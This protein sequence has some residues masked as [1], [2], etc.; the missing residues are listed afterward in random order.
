MTFT[1]SSEQTSIFTHIS[2]GTGNLIVS[3]C[4]GSGKTTTILHAFSHIP[5]SS[6]FVPPSVLYLVFN[7][8]NAT[9]AEDK[10][11]RMNVKNVTVS[12]FHALGMRALKS[13][14]LFSQADMQKRDFVNARK[15][16]RLVFNA[17][18]RENPDV[19]QVIRL[20]G[21]LKQQVWESSGGEVDVNPS[22]I[23]ALCAHFEIDLT[24]PEQSIKTALDILQ[25]STRDLS[26]IDFDDMLYLPIVLNVPFAPWDWV[27]TDEAQ[28]TNDVRMEIL[29]RLAKPFRGRLI[30]CDGMEDW[31]ALA[32]SS[33][34]FISVGDP[35]QAI[36]GFTGANSNALDKL[37]D[38]FQCTTLPLSISYRC[39]QNVVKESQPYG[40]IFPHPSAPLGEILRP[41]TYEPSMFKPPC[42]IVCRNT[43]PLV[44]FAYALLQ[45][46]IPCTVLGRDIGTQLTTLVKKM[47]ALNIVDLSD[48]L[49]AWHKRETERL[50]DKDMSTQ[51]IDDQ[52]EC[53]V[54][55]I[56]SL[57]EDSQSVASVLAKIDLMFSEEPGTSKVTLSTVHKAK[58]LEYPTVFILDRARYMPSRFARLPWQQEQERNLI[59]VAMTRAMERLV[60]IQ[61]ECWKEEKI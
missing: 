22:R 15:V 9:E 16:P 45:R 1:P 14:G 4:P 41:D 36:Y 57:D 3:A 24:T 10:L 34:R 37:R 30:E 17:M 6:G 2:K 21:I 38:K 27:F 35:A 49:I 51:R 48:K 33:T 13:S 18:D 26:C 28:D 19:A 61:S 59:F 50:I 60:F 58:G 55:F 54:Y 47:C 29:T 32:M 56:S 5:Q 23:E 52:Y 53:L 44:G 25:R 39:P 40:T 42:I 20:V 43:A 12:T 46:D 7:K 8:R 31:D 11:R